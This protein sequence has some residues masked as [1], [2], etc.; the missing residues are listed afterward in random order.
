MMKKVPAWVE[1][2]G[3]VRHA[4]SIKLYW[5]HIKMRVKWYVMDCQKM[6]ERGSL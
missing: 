2:V 1:V 5:G 4:S 6:D 3:I